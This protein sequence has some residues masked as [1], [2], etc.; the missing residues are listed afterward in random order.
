VGAVK[1]M[2]ERPDGGAEK[3]I[4]DRIHEIGTATEDMVFE[5]FFAGSQKLT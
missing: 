2:E 1:L 4:I 3:E 5:R